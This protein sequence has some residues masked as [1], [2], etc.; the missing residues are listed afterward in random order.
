MA[1]LTVIQ[2]AA[3]ATEVSLAKNYSIKSNNLVN[4]LTSE[5]NTLK[6]DLA[7]LVLKVQ[8]LATLLSQ[9]DIS[10]VSSSSFQ[11]NNL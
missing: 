9:A 4:D 8:N 3:L 11:Y 5:V 10:G 7:T 1:D 6:T 2:S